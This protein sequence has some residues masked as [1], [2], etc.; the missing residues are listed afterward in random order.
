MIANAHDVIAQKR[1]LI[2]R[3]LQKEEQGVPGVDDAERRTILVD[4][5]DVI[6]APF[7]H[8]RPDIAQMV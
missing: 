6:Q 8:D 4:D 1:L 5:G 2:L 3:T 7:F